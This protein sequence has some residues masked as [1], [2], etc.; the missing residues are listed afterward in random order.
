MD[1]EGG[2]ISFLNG[3][4]PT[5]NPLPNMNT[6]RQLGGFPALKTE[7]ETE[8]THISKQ[9]RILDTIL[10]SVSLM[11]QLVGIHIL[12]NQKDNYASAWCKNVLAEELYL[13]LISWTNMFLLRFL[14]YVN[15][16]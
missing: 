9:A 4:G 1:T 7:W 16:F 15:I 8:G 10:A 2:D 14:E 13:L 6:F 3:C 5:H 12:A 11:S